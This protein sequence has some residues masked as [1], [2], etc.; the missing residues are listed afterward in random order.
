MSHTSES[1]APVSRRR[2]AVL[3]AARLVDPGHEEAFQEWARG[4]LAAASTL[5]GHLGGGLFQPSG[6]GA[7]WIVV[8]RFR[9]REAMR[10]WTESP[11]RAAFFDD[12]RGHRHHEV[13][14]RELAGLEA[15]FS[16]PGAPAAPPPRWK[17][18]ASSAVGIFPVSLLGSVFLTPHLTALPQVARTAV[19]AVLFSVLMTYVSM[20]LVT[21]ALRR[22]LAP[23]PPPP[24]ST[25]TSNP[26]PPFNRRTS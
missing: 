21:R 3:V 16:A 1:T 8:H 20:P 14:L 11:Q 17:M 22:W 4:V 19:F 26:N 25:L 10:A 15:W 18:A 24:H 13:A 7:P 5:P 12:P 6:A 9:D 2:D 23:A